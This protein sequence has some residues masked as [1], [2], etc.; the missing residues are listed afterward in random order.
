[1]AE[2]RIYFSRLD[3]LRFIAFSLVFWQHG[4]AS[5]IKHADFISPF[6]AESVSMTGGYG[7]HIFFVLSGFLITFLLLKEQQTS[8]AISIRNFYM[9]RVLRI[10]PLYYLI[11]I[12]GIFILPS[13]INTFQFCG[14]E[15]MH[16]VFLNNFNNH[17][18]AGCEMPNV[19][20][21]WSVAIEEQFYLVWPLIFWLF[22]RSKKLLILVTTLLF[23]GSVVFNYI[24]SDI[25]Y[26]HTLGNTMYLMM[27]CF[28][29]VLF[30]IR[31]DFLF[32]KRVFNPLMFG[33]VLA[34]FIVLIFTRIP[35][36]LVLFPLLYL[37]IILYLADIDTRSVRSSVFS[38]LGKYTYGMYMYH[39]TIII[40]AKIIFDKTGINYMNGGKGA[41]L[42]AL[43][44]LILTILFSIISYNYFEK[45]F[46]KLKGRFTSVQTRI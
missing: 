9:R 17:L 25:S 12:T 4:F 45:I 38:R 16:L 31:P 44:A 6:V 15:W 23:F 19:G 33:L 24:Y 8:G 41:I 5:V 2:N 30:Y 11:M 43:L 18:L 34:V 28:G 21:A 35:V 32:Q 14:E 46:L 37:Y 40:F 22:S 13:L 7:V 26:F 29:G 20:I 27:G 42:L 39:P 36:R 3:I 1:M 10:W